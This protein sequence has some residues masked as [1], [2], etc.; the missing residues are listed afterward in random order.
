MGFYTEAL[1]Q[2]VQEAE[3]QGKWSPVLVR[4]RSSRERGDANG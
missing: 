1:Q 3:S 4:T 2:A